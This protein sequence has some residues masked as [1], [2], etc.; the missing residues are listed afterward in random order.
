MPFRAAALAY[1]AAILFIQM[2]RSTAVPAYEKALAYDVD[3]S[4]RPSGLEVSAKSVRRAV[5]KRLLV[6]VGDGR[7]YLDRAAVR[8]SDRRST[9][10]LVL[11]TGA[12]IPLLWL[13][14]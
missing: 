10:I 1:P 14:I 9:L 8:R 12:F 3:S 4:R 2:S 11:A 13:L 6:P 5:R 7:F